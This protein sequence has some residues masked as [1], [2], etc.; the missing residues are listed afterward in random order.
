MR[1]EILDCTIRDGGYINNWKFEKKS[2]R[3]IYRALSKSGIDYMEIG[4]R[5]NRKHF[6]SKKYG[7]WRFS[8]EEVIQEV[9]TNIS[10]AKLAL[11][12]DYGTVEVDDFCDIKYSTVELIRVAT[13]KNKLK[14]A[15]LLLK[16]IKKKGY[17]VS[18][19][20]MGYTSYTDIERN[21]M[22]DMLKNEEVDY[23][24]IAD[25]YGSLFP[26]QVRPLIEPLLNI[27]NIKIGF[28][29]HNNLQMA[30]ANTLEA[31][32]CGVHII[33]ST[34]YGMG[35][36]AGNLP[37]E[38]I[39]AYM[40][41]LKA[42][43]YNSVPI[44]NI[45][46]RYFITLQ[47]E[48]IWGYQLPYML[49]GMFQCHPNYAKTLT[50][51]REYTIEDIQKAM[52]QIY[53]QNPIGYSKSLLDNIIMEGIIGSNKKNFTQIKSRTTNKELSYSY[54]NNSVPYI[55][56]HESR[57]FLIL[58]NGPSLKEYKR[59]IDIFIEKYDPIILGAN[60]L[61][62]L[63]NPHYHAFNNKRRLFE[64][65]DTVAQESKLIIGQYIPDVMVREYTNRSYEKFYYVD[66]LDSDFEIKDGII[67]TNCRT[68]AVLLIG[69]AIVMGAR[70]IFC[71]GL[72]GYIGLNKE[73]FHFYN[74][75]NEKDNQEMIMELHYWN[76]EF[77][78]QINEYLIKRNFEGV[79]I[80]TPTSYKSYY[81]GID[82]F[83]E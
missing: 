42:N 32:K 6:D 19:N 23:V 12:V 20:A 49:S 4:F 74:E 52:E 37:T 26:D 8:T 79:H 35:R 61:G 17:K 71:A 16:D 41:R 50:E 66:V 62:G 73:R 34:I 70:R 30:F 56:R 54:K 29:P 3:E 55:N 65:I 45:I 24:Y 60:Y 31:L 57:V 47:K 11:M 27:Q 75:K 28:H 46:D 69:V 38:I 64:Y 68:I 15:F 78:D 58:A 51:F 21:N 53:K 2:V 1:T 36:A 44:L 63:F 80:I 82:N 40:E 18:L 22:L 43:K 7:L 83:I 72:D 48:N 14:E 33:D 67:S 76:K 59:K 25:S 13:H 10:G 5:S 39:I 81:K 77:I 9:T